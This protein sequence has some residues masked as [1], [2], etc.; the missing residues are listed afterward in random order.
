M[1][2]DLSVLCI[3]ELSYV[4]IGDNCLIR[5]MYVNNNC[6][7]EFLLGRMLFNFSG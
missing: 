1:D 7:D 2:N 3:D 5:R 6:I 4:F